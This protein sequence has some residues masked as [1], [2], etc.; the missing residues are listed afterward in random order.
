M[1]DASTCKWGVFPHRH[2]DM[3]LA[4]E[5]PQMTFLQSSLLINARINPYVK[6]ISF[7]IMSDCILLCSQAESGQLRPW[8]LRFIISEHHFCVR[9]LSRTWAVR[10]MRRHKVCDTVG[11]EADAVLVK[12]R[13]D[14]TDILQIHERFKWHVLLNSLGNVPVIQQR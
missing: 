3:I 11:L 10:T 1:K 4:E 6:Q 12:I 2:T 13:R 7:Y 9:V 5:V 14:H 8:L